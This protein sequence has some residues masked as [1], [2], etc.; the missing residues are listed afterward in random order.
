MIYLRE[1]F[2]KTGRI[3]I[4]TFKKSILKV[5]IKHIINV[6]VTDTQTILRMIFPPNIALTF[7]PS[8]MGLKLIVD[9]KTFHLTRDPN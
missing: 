2:T 1:V 8:V 7:P 6:R 5:K 9:S 4:N 3:S